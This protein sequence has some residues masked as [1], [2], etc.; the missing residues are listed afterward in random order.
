MTQSGRL[1]QVT[2]NQQS[3]APWRRALKGIDRTLM[4]TAALLLSQCSWATWAFAQVESA[5]A[6]TTARLIQ[7]ASR[8][9]AEQKDDAALELLK[10]GVA[11]SPEDET[12]VM[13]LAK[14]YMR[15][16]NTAWATRV[17]SRYIEEHALACNPRMLLI[18]IQMR[19]GLIRPA[20]ELLDGPGCGSP[21]EVKARWHLIAAYLDLLEKKQVPATEHLEVAR[22]SPALFEEDEALLAYLGGETEPERTARVTGLANLAL[23]WTSH[24]LAGSPIDQAARKS[25]GTPI[26]IIDARLRWMLLNAGT[27]RPLLE[28]QLR[29]QQLWSGETSALSFRTITGRAGFQLRR[30]LPRV[31]WLAVFDGTQIQGGDRYAAGPIWFSE[32][33]R[34]EF[35]L[36][37]P[38]SVLLMIGGGHRAFR[39]LA[40]SRAEFDATLGWAAQWGAQ[41]RFLGGL[42][43]R[44]H[45]AKNQAYDLG[46][47]TAV[48][49]LR[50]YLPHDFELGATLAV[51]VDNHFRSGGYFSSLSTR[52]DVQWQGTGALYLPPIAQLRFLARYEL[53]ARRSS[54]DAYEFTDH[55]FLAALE[56]SIDSERLTRKTVAEQG[57]GTIDYGT[58]G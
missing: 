23:G 49:Q 41:T 38:H 18:W 16:G 19:Q 43:G 45:D 2:T 22:N 32:G 28:G 9:H 30:E 57:R 7:G 42:S 5:P 54:V 53:T 24:G 50:R 31:T 58:L 4:M 14:A 55:R 12:L 46:G 52:R 37:L 3:L 6:E 13:A 17:L 21:P 10:A 27:V 56:W 51:A 34:G 35:E 25:S 29:A 15:K 40:R 48:S 1:Q 47:F 8:L 36:E 20:R 44:Y 11:H 39:D 33:K 26:G